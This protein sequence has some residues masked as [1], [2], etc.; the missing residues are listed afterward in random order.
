[1]RRVSRRG[2]WLALA[3][4]LSSAARTR[5]VR[6]DEIDDCIAAAEESQRLRLDGKLIRAR[7][8]LLVCSSGTCP[9]IVRSDCAR[10][11][12]ELDAIVP[13]VIVRALDPEGHDVPDVHAAVDGEP[14]AGLF[15]GKEIR[16]DPGPHVFRFTRGSGPPVAQTVVVAPRE[17]HQILS[18]V[19]GPPASTGGKTQLPYE[20]A[21]PPGGLPAQR[22]RETPSTRPDPF[23]PWY[24]AMLGTGALALGTASYFWISG[25]ADHGRLA[26]T[27]GVSH[28]CSPSAV[29]SAHSDLVVGDVVGAAGGSLAMLGLT[30]LIFRHGGRQPAATAMWQPVP[31]GALLGIQGSF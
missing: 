8:Q 18:I 25:L 24:F 3:L 2:P 19:F 13:S 23:R 21:M 4:V 22:A 14:I 16:L 20:S 10:W 27:C 11:S 28:S 5:G 31:G 1:M 30:L 26:S 29:D 15:G 17:Q 6:A 7:E 9:T 12:S